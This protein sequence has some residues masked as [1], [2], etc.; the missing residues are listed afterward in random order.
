[1][2]PLEQYENLE[3]VAEG[4]LK[5]FRAREVNSHRPVLLHQ[6]S[7]RPGSGRPL[8]LLTR[9]LRYTSG[10]SPGSQNPILGIEELE[11]AVWV[12]TEDRPELVNLWEWLDQASGKRESPPAAP[13]ASPAAQPQETAQPSSNSAEATLF[14]SSSPA[15]QATQSMPASSAPLSSREET[16]GDSTLILQRSETA[17]FS[18]PAS[19]ES[20]TPS[21]SP[22]SNQPG[23]FTML[24][25]TKRPQDFPEK[26]PPPPQPQEPAVKPSDRPGE[27][28][29][30]FGKPTRGSGDDSR[31]RFLGYTAPMQNRSAQADPSATVVRNLADETIAPRPDPP[32]SPPDAPQPGEFTRMFQI[33]HRDLPA[34]DQTIP[35]L[36]KAEPPAL[37]QP[38]E[39]TQVFRTS[40]STLVSPN[41]PGLNEPE[42]KEPG[43]FTRIFRIPVGSDLL[44]EPQPPLSSTE[45]PPSEAAFTAG[46]FQQVAEE[47]QPPMAPVAQTSPPPQ[48]SAPPSIPA[49]V[50]LPKAP[51]EGM[52]SAPAIKVPGASP[53][54]QQPSAPS[55]S[56]PRFAP[57]PMPQAPSPMAPFPQGLQAPKL[58][59]QPAA[60]SGPSWLPIAL[61]FG[62]IIL[63]AVLLVLFFL[64]K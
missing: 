28:T 27:F 45:K 35:D 36:L 39:F 37:G 54:P 32:S 38:G 3:A 59:E 29:M 62:G 22:G 4:E 40:D 44:T 61:V 51:F 15:P 6:L 52:P 41:P 12:I 10:L 58:P 11:D 53:A 50:A 43:A 16:A 31:P 33:P 13:P 55:F 46:A 17:P 42:H 25:Q 47:P 14:L 9:I 7:H 20:A 26:A 60:A 24:F 5:T 30:V 19:T 49:A 1:M 8:R 57:P 48:P 63:I 56:V 64:T 2:N 34:S 23:E 18:A 21:P